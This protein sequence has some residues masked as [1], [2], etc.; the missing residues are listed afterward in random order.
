MKTQEPEV[1]PEPEPEEAPVE[2]P[3]LEELI[4]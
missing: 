3:T 2:G 1:I 4:N